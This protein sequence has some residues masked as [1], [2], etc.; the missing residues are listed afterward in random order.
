[1]ARADMQSSNK[2]NQKDVQKRYQ[3]ELKNYQKQIEKTKKL[4]GKRKIA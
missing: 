3:H 1:M 2:T 4:L